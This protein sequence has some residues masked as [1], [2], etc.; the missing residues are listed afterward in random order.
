MGNAL[1]L[2]RESAWSAGA[3]TPGFER[4]VLTLHRFERAM[5]RRARPWTPALAGAIVAAMALLAVLQVVTHQET[6]APL[7][8]RGH[9][10]SRLEEPLPA[11]PELRTR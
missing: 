4:R 3:S 5:L 7:S 11:F 2:L 6:L 9:E 10:A 1:N 8:L